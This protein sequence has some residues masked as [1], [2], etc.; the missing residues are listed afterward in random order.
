MRT[1]IFLSAILMTITAVACGG[2]DDT[3]DETTEGAGGAGAAGAS[4]GNGGTAGS[5]TA[6]KGGT[7]GTAGS[8]GSTAGNGGTAGGAGKG[9]SSAGSGGSTAGSGGSNAGSGGSSAGAGGSS[10]GSGGSTAGSG[11]S[12]AGSGGSSAGSGGSTAGSG[13]ST[14]G[15]GGSTAGSGGSAGTGSN[16]KCSPSMPC[17]SDE[18]CDYSDQLCG[19]SP[20]VG[21]CKTRPQGCSLNLQP[22]CGCDGKV[23]GNA[24]NAYA[25]GVDISNAGCPSPD[26]GLFSCGSGFCD[27][28]TQYC[29]KIGSDVGSIPDDY[30]CQ[31][32]PPVCNGTPSCDCLGKTVC[33]MFTCDATSDGGFLTVCPG[34][35]ST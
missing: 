27:K 32:I 3:T 20:Y 2:S 28:A 12:I 30:M 17:G 15:S 11:G 33:G 13:G 5:G 35:L 14:A 19:K 18:Y 1:T 9:G 6:G 7:A 34:G 24:C 10:A 22:A 23:Y 16:A 21:H 8:S 4:A 26:P 31:P 25:A 29:Q